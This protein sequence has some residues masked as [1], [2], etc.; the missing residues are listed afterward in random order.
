MGRSAFLIVGLALA[1]C[2]GSDPGPEAAKP[3]PSATADRSSGLDQ[4]QVAIRRAVA[5]YY[6]AYAK[7]DFEAVCATLVPSER[8]HFD[9]KGGR[10][11]RVFAQGAGRL[12]PRELKQ[13][14]ELEA[15]R[16]RIEGDRATIT[17][18]N[19]YFS[20][21]YGRLYALREDGEWGITRRKAR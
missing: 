19:A 20:G 17:L 18:T 5:R 12:K 21:R 11:A 6:D 2:G 8:R 13:L 1:G 15:D 9:R 16:I 4:D 14:G 7:K 3:T 10:C